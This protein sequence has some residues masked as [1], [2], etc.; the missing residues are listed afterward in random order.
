MQRGGC[1]QFEEPWPKSCTRGMGGPRL[2]VRMTRQI[3][4][5]LDLVANHFTILTSKSR[6]SN[7]DLLRRETRR[8]GCSSK[9]RKVD[10]LR[11]D[12]I[13]MKVDFM[14]EKGFLNESELSCIC[15]F[16]LYFV[17][18]KRFG[19]YGIGRDV[20]VFEDYRN[21]FTPKNRWIIVSGG[22]G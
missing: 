14:L 21:C 9:Q 16:D 2:L 15:G 8:L 12:C 3:G 13:C 5:G 7:S 22:R 4:I 18:R 10:V 20:G 11:G 6:Y 1:P 19:G 17:V